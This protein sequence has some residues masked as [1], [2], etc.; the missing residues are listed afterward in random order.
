MKSIPLSMIS[1][2]CVWN[3]FAQ[4]TETYKEIVTTYSIPET[5][6]QQFKLN[7]YG[8]YS[9]NE[10]KYEQATSNNSMLNFTLY[11][12]YTYFFENDL[13]QLDFKTSIGNFNYNY[14]LNSYKDLTGDYKTESRLFEL[15][16]E[17]K[18]L[19][20]YFPL[21]N[22]Q[23]F[24]VLNPHLNYS[25]S[26]FTQQNQADL[27]KVDDSK[28]FILQGGLGIGFGQYRNIT[29][30]ITALRFIERLKQKNVI[31]SDPSKETITSLAQQFQRRNYYS[32]VY[33][34]PQKY[35]YADVF[36]I[37]NQ[38]H[39][40]ISKDTQSFLYASETFS[41]FK[42]SRYEGFDVFIQPIL[43]LH[44][45]DQDILNY[46]ETTSTNFYSDQKMGG[47]EINGRYASQLSFESQ[48]LASINYNDVNSLRDTYTEKR[49]STLQ[50]KTEVQYE[51]T[52]K[53]LTSIG[54]N[55]SSYSQEK[56]LPLTINYN[57]KSHSFSASGFYFIE[58]STTIQLN[59]SL[60]M[61][62]YDTSLENGMT[63][64]YDV[65]KQTLVNI[66]FGLT[67]YFINSFSD[68]FS[69]TTF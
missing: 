52:D 31:K 12:H 67:H 40:E 14:N 35:F 68:S 22:S 36:S 60:N 59:L 62:D 65:K 46:G 16:L 3:L 30:V 55:Y 50:F 21:E 51:W 19:F 44:F 64:P 58:N 13:N 20:K 7:S 69:K 24:I 25:I 57:K 63:S 53:L 4:S 37:L 15:I 48:F 29:S 27:K 10:N 28:K 8:N 2:L 56:R 32:D 23:I 11:P 42:F 49:H 26:K 61:N 1:I 18:L 17:S 5:K 41:E 39:P 66:S 9:S 47:F 34:R 6:Y 38:V 54:Y 45:K 33:Q 43:F